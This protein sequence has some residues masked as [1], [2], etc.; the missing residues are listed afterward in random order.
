MYILALVKKQWLVRL[1]WIAKGNMQDSPNKRRSVST[2]LTWKKCSLFRASH[3]LCPDFQGTGRSSLCFCGSSSST[4]VESTERCVTSDALVHMDVV[5]LF[6]EF[7][8]NLS[9]LL[10][11][12]WDETW[13]D[14]FGK[15]GWEQCA[16]TMRLAVARHLR[17]RERLQLEKQLTEAQEVQSP[18]KWGRNQEIWH[19]WTRKWFQFLT[20]WISSGRVDR[21]YRHYNCRILTDWWDLVGQSV[22][23]LLMTSQQRLTSFRWLYLI[24]SSVK[25]KQYIFTILCAYPSMWKFY[26]RFSCLP[27]TLH[28]SG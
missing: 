11:V 24:Y 22:R 5:F 12:T 17:S 26:N 3:D 6:S 4:R 18:K 19:A 1:L 7:T 16:P 2:L 15:V 9:L 20:S 8:W 28:V 21:W 13:W 14:S 27:V 10:E 23:N 25:Y